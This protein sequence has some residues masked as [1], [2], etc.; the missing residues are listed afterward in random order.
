MELKDSYIQSLAPDASGFTNGKKLAADGSFTKLCMD[1]S[2]SL[3]FGEC[4]GSG[5]RPYIVSVDFSGGEPVSRCSC[6][7]RKSPCKHAI[8][9]MLCRAAGK[10]FTFSPVPQDII[11][12]RAKAEKKE[13]RKAAATV[14]GGGDKPAKPKKVNVAALKKKIG[15]QL[16]GLAIGEKLLREIAA[17]GM[18][19][20]S[21]QKLRDLNNQVVKLGDYYLPG[22]QRE[23]RTLL[24]CFSHLS[25]DPE[26]DYDAGFAQMLELSQLIKNGRIYLTQKADDPVGSLDYKTEIESQLGYA[27]QLSELAELGLCKKDARLTQLCFF[28]HDDQAAM[29]Y[30]DLGLWMDLDGGAIYKRQ[31]FRPYRAARH[32][33]QEDTQSG[34]LPV[35]ELYLYPGGLNPRIRWDGV[36][37]PITPGPADYARM[38]A[39]AKEDYAAVLKSVKEQLKTPLSDKNPYLLLAYAGIGKTVNGYCIESP[40]GERI[41]LV[42]G[43]EQD[44]PD[45]SWLLDQGMG[46]SAG[47][48]LCRFRVSA[49]LK[50]LNASPLSLVGRDRLIRLAF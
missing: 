11:E 7:S 3:L 22:I 6:P 33:P 21:P 12:K 36:G 13:A 47:A 30:E 1:E 49:D 31:N 19:S 46:D 10:S 32:I 43:G 42:N 44:I 48:A 34:V 4:Q 37:Q 40:G 29:Q 23:F 28:C 9:L 17:G 24:Y 39:L 18:A 8:G 14:A 25:D 15:S 38:L 16:E 5:D 45:T 2:G 26:G 20:L 27:W 35:G 50:T 41:G